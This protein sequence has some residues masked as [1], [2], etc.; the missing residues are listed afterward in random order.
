MYS[1]LVLYASLSGPEYTI[2]VAAFKRIL[3]PLVLPQSIRSAER[4]IRL[5]ALA[6]RTSSHV[7]HYL[8]SQTPFPSFKEEL[9]SRGTP[10][11]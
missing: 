6:E 5:V 8:L 2:T 7:T 1:I 3:D 11:C 10:Y 9:R 4:P